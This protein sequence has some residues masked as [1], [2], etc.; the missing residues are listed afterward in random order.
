LGVIPRLIDLGV[1]PFL[2]SPSLSLAIAQRLIRTL[3]PKCKKEVKPKKEIKDLILK[4]IEEM[5]EEVKKN[6][7]IKND[8]KIFEPRGC[9]ECQEKGYV[10]RIALFEVLEMT[11]ELGEIILKEPSELKIFQEAKRQGMLTMRQDGI[12]K[13]LEGITTIEEVLRETT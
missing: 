11:K 6:L 12:L 5:P 2:I 8:F 4:E 1:Q 3:C 10:G 9:S 7:K 13:V